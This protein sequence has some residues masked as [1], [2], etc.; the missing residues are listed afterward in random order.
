MTA[1]EVKAKILALLDEVAAGEE[2]EIT[3]HG[4]AIARLVAAPGPTLSR[5]G[6]PGSR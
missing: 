4:R 2:I 5:V 1:T 3:K 6:C